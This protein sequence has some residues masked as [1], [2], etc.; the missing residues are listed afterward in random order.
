MSSSRLVPYILAVALLTFAATP[1]VAMGPNVVPNG[2]AEPAPAD[3]VM[4]WLS[5]VWSWLQDLLRAPAG[6][7]KMGPTV[8]P[9]G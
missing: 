1:V 5:D 8:S 9:H 7:A 2:I 4:V 3:G 6:P